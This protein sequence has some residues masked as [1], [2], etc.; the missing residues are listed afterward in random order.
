[1]NQ[2]GLLI[3]LMELQI[4]FT[5][6]LYSHWND[7]V[8]SF[9][10][11]SLRTK[12]NSFFVFMQVPFCVCFH[13]PYYW[14]SPC[15]WRRFQSYYGWGIR[16]WVE[17]LILMV[18]LYQ[19]LL[20]ASLFGTCYIYHYKFLWHNSYSPVSKGK[21]PSLMENQSKVGTLY[22]SLTPYSLEI[23]LVKMRIMFF[24]L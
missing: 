8:F 5:G 21:E 16:L 3:L 23:L 13:W 9:W 7:F 14:E 19:S 10:T 20:Q 11:V 1:M 12:L 4:S 6:I 2:L 15:G 17:T 18:T 24:S 22:T